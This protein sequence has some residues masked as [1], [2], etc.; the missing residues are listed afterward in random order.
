MA[1]RVQG[2]LPGLSHTGG[3][4]PFGLQG[5]QALQGLQGSPYGLQGNP[6]MG[7]VAGM[8]PGLSHTAGYGMISPQAYGIA[9]LQ[10]PLLTQSILQNPLAAGLIQQQGGLG[11]TGSDQVL[12]LTFPFA[13]W[14]YSPFMSAL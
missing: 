8:V 7:N 5:L 6:L 2:M 12:A 9:G 14:S 11:H 13:Q 10:N 1:A 3:L 4:S